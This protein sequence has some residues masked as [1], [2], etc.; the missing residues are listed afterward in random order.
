MIGQWSHAKIDGFGAFNEV[1]AENLN[2][3]KRRTARN[4]VELLVYRCMFGRALS[5]NLPR[6]KIV[7]V[8]A[9]EPGRVWL[10]NG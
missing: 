8:F 10:M 1:V 3:S 4:D 9:S 2:R 5:R 6:L 7:P